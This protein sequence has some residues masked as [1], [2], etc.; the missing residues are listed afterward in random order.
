[1]GCAYRAK[2][3]HSI[4]W[5][6]AGANGEVTLD[7]DDNVEPDVVGYRVHRSAAAGGPYTDISG[8]LGV[9]TYSDTAVVNGT[10]YYYYVTAEDTSGNMS[11]PSAS[12]SATPEGSSSG[13]LVVSSIDMSTSGN[14][15]KKVT[16]TVAMVDDA[17]VPVS[18]AL[19]TGTFSGDVSGTQQ[20][21]TDSAGIARF[22]NGTRL[23]SP[24][25]VTFC[26]DSAEKSGLV[27]DELSLGC[28]TISF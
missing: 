18:G 11:S 25:T 24:A 8:L 7:W 19:V 26:V 21:N 13:L 12:S 5:V 14:K 1:M 6:A 2:R 17:G 4:G 23:K 20:I 3:T 27:L 28:S 10:T 15:T 16:A 9:S 22:Q